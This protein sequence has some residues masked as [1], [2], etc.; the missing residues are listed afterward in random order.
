MRQALSLV[1]ELGTSC[2][3]L[4]QGL[5]P[6]DSCPTDGCAR[7]ELLGPS[8]NESGRVHLN[9]NWEQTQR[10]VELAQNPK[11]EVGSVSGG[12]HVRMQTKFLKSEVAY[13]HPSKHAGQRCQLC[14]HFI[15]PHGCEGVAGYIRR[16]DWCSKFDGGK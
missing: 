1:D 5:L 14:V 12:K 3:L 6:K 2:S 9:P 8:G 13:E 4:S 10:S 15:S 7:L 16:E 11:K